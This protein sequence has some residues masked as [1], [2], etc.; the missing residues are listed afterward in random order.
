MD[1]ESRKLT[2]RNGGGGGTSY[3]GVSSSSMLLLSPEG[4]TEISVVKIRTAMINSK[5]RKSRSAKVSIVVEI[6]LVGLGLL[7]PSAIDVWL[8]SFVSEK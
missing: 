4:R 7:A 5:V 8:F 3:C 6:G 2:F 1:L